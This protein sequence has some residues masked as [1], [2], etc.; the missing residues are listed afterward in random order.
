MSGTDSPYN[1]SSN[2][3]PCA[4]SIMLCP[5]EADVSNILLYEI[6][7]KLFSIVLF[8]VITEVKNITPAPITYNI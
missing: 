4:S 3:L 2:N 6:V 8:S 7:L 1:D 5:I